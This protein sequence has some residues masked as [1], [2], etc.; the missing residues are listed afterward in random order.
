M[1]GYGIFFLIMTILLIGLLLFIKFSKKGQSFVCNKCP[2][3]PSGQRIGLKYTSTNDAIVNNIIN[4]VNTTIDETQKKYLKC[5]EAANYT[6]ELPEKGT[7]CEDYKKTLAPKLV[8]TGQKDADDAQKNALDSFIKEAC[9]S[10]GTIDYDKLSAS[11]KIL[12]K[13]FC[14]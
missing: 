14:V 11:S 4:T 12:Q 13:T 5:S 2:V 10:D 6:L 1:D 8:T 3:C 9:L 7:K